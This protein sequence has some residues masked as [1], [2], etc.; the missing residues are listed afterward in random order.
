MYLYFSLVYYELSTY[1]NSVTCFDYKTKTPDNADIADRVWF[2]VGQKQSLSLSIRFSW[3]RPLI[4]ARADSQQVSWRIDASRWGLSA[5]VQIIF[6]TCQT[7]QDF[8]TI[9]RWIN[10][11]LQ[12]Y[13]FF[14]DWRCQHRGLTRGPSVGWGWYDGS[15]QQYGEFYFFH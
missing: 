14:K 2:P 5:T 1:P 12:A 11:I 7:I 10:A 4:D 15:Y 3:N 9:T 13:C 6:V 8:Q